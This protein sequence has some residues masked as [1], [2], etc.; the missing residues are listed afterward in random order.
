MLSSLLP[1]ILPHSGALDAITYKVSVGLEN[2][3]LD[4]LFLVLAFTIE[5]K[6]SLLGIFTAL[7]FV[8]IGRML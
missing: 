2:I 8:V 3:K 5:F 6:I 4:L 1:M 7:I